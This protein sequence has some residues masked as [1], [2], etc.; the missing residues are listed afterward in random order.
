MHKRINTFITVCFFLL[1]AWAPAILAEP[2]QVADFYVATSGN[3]S[4][5]GTVAAPFASIER[6]QQAVRERIITGLSTN[7][8]VVIHRGVYKITKPLKFTPQDSGTLQY[9]ITY[10]TLT[11]ENVLI[12]G[13]REITGWTK[14]DGNVWTAQISEVHEGKW[15]FRNLF[16]NGRRATRAR[17]PNSNAAI[18]YF[19]LGATT[20]SPDKLTWT[21]ALPSG[22][23]ASWKNIADVEFILLLPWDNY[24]KRVQSVSPTTGTIVLQP[25]YVQ[26]HW[27]ME[28][29]PG[30]YCYLENARAFLDQP[31]EWYLDHVSGTLSYWPRSDEDLNNAE[32]IAPHLT[33]LLQILGTSHQ[34]VCNL[35]FKGLCFAYT[36]DELPP[37][38]FLGLGQGMDG[39]NYDADVAPPV[40]DSIHWQFATGCTIEDCEIAHCGRNGLWLS[41]G[42][43]HNLIRGNHFSDL[44][45]QG[46]IVGL[47]RNPPQT[48]P[49]AIE[50]PRWNSIANN[51]IEDCGGTYYG[52]SGV[53][54]LFAQHSVISHNLIHD[55]SLHGISVATTMEIPPPQIADGY[56]IENNLIHDVG[57]TLSDAGGIYIW[58]SQTNGIIRGNVVHN[59]VKSPY[60]YYTE[61]NGIYFDD[62]S[63]GYLVESNIVFE[64]A[65]KALQFTNCKSESDE[66]RDNYW[67]GTNQFVQSK[68][69]G[70]AIAFS[71]N[72]FVDVPNEPLLEPTEMTVEVWANLYHLPE[73]KDPSAWLISKGPDELTDGHYALLV[74][75][76]NL[77]AYLNI[78]GGRD[79]TFSA[80][81]S[82][83][84][85]T[86]NVWHHL[87]FTYDGSVLRV[88]CDGRI[89]GT[90]T[91]R[92]SR[93][94]G[95]GLLRIGKRA[96]GYNPS[97]PGLI[98]QVRIYNRA[99]SMEEISGQ[100]SV[101]SAHLAGGMADKTAVSSLNSQVSGLPPSLV[102]DWNATEVYAGMERILK[103]AGPEEPYRCRFRDQKSEI[104]DQKPESAAEKKNAD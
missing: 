96:D 79:H 27:P 41:R 19:K 87:A 59:I 75:H 46:I 1:L 90:N 42:C 30:Y 7:I 89:V 66:L 55:V 14:G 49:S 50:Q 6:A 26:A 11:N 77:G 102:F 12:S 35:H 18:P 91:V 64:C 67:N 45:G 69:G 93:T 62:L 53:L 85:V 44:N 52:T 15:Y 82:D 3:D 57:K 74:S 95:N 101:A 5:P 61:L 28:P 54:L 76:Q 40:Q 9:S 72:Y 65:G 103:S 10:T 92:L 84:P 4:N 16:V 104:K 47:L 86:A 37:Q 94:P 83:G 22:Q 63:R 73:S 78:G 100:Y 21:M 20:I 24:R 71:N 38:G 51:L 48:W 68:D 88:Y 8:I 33:S 99:L 36:D 81:S 25:P 98:R 80:W 56:L 13:G 43:D 31:G 34:P 32:V 39:A 97:F 2:N 23:I 58:G 70:S 17:Q 60:A 29:T